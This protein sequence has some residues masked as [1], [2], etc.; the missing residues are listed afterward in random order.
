MK[1]KG[2]LGALLAATVAAA[3]FAATPRRRAPGG[4][5]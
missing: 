5:S 3:A 4:R 1:T 2:I